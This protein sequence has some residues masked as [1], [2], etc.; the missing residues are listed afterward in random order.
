MESTRQ[1]KISRLLQKELAIIFQQNAPAILGNFM[2]TITGV[3]VSSD[4][5]IAK[6]YLSIFPIT[7]SKKLMKEVKEK[8][9]F[10]R[11]LLA[12]KVRHQLRIIPELH[13]F[14]DDSADYADEINRLL[15]E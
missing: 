8:S 5:F 11:N 13:F 6:V 7:D 3:R 2:F 4:L 1:K 12:K 9:S 10:F 15:K 14:L